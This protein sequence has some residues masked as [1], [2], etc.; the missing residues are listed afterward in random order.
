MAFLSRKKP[1]VA[2]KALPPAVDIE[3]ID[4]GLNDAELATLH[5]F[6]SMDLD[7]LKQ[8]ASGDFSPPPEPSDST[9]GELIESIRLHV[10]SA[11]G[12]S[13]VLITELNQEA[14]TLSNYCSEGVAAATKDISSELAQA[15]ET[16]DRLTAVAA[17]ER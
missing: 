8:L 2:S 14:A 10:G 7:F 6:N 1:S 13:K 3:Q 17:A 16:R 5:D 11:I 12:K 4:R 15:R 9:A